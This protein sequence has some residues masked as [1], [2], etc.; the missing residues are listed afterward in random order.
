MNYTNKVL[1]VICGI[2]LLLLGAFGGVWWTKQH[3]TTHEQ[4]P[5]SAQQEKQVLYWYDP[6]M[7]QQRFDKPG[8][9]PMDME[10]IPMYADDD[11]ASET[12]GVKIDSA[13]AQNL[14]V[15][16]ATVTRIPLATQIE[17]T[18]VISFNERDVAVVQTRSG[19]YVERVW[20]LAPGD[21]IKAGQPLVELLVPEW[22]AA[23]HELLAVKTSRDENLI[24]AARERLRLLGMAEE[25]IREVEQSGTVRSRF[26]INAPIAGVIQSLDVR[27]GMTV[28]AGQGVARLNGLDTVWLDVAIPEAMAS[29]VREGAVAQ[30][31][32]AAFPEKTLKG[33]VTAILPA[34]NDAT[35][36]LR[37]RVE[38]SNR[39]GNLRP[40]LSAQVTLTSAQQESALAV[41]TEAI[42]RTG[43]RALVMMAGDKNRYT[44]VEVAL[45]REVGNQ[46]VIASGVSEGQQVVASGQFLIDSE[47]SLK[48][49]EARSSGV[50]Q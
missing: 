4:T 33:R 2:A 14:G 6:M 20:P 36:T 22:S 32:L 13:A 29:A 7:P 43:K 15:R 26:T 11:E 19:G 10:L 23:Q 9:S 5:P 17:A 3:T 41:P 49:I 39:D 30:A 21:V 12:T 40:G 42:I 38:L 47:A 37:V 16:L 8:K 27:G 28:M 25:S 31:H 50:G 18:G 44:P 35:R 45:G 1:M 46:T 34:L 48:G 24:A